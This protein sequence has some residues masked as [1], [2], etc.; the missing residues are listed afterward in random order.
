MAEF[1]NEMA[2]NEITGQVVDASMKVHTQ[3]GPGLLESAYEAC[4]AYELRQRRLGVQSQV[5]LPVQ[6]E[7]VD[8]DV[9]YRIDVF[10][11]S[12]VIVELKAVEA[13]S[14]NH[15]A[16]I[17]NYLKA[18]NLRTGLVINFGNPKIEYRRFDNRY[19]R[20]GK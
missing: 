7:D 9:G 4:L 13:L 17:I 15:F 3:L 19:L 16:Q 2:L 12:R 18:T 11:E 14:K 6:Y 20:S 10:V 5:A 1:E 8:L